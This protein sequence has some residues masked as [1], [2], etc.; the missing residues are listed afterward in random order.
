MKDLESGKVWHKVVTCQEGVRSKGGKKGGG[1]EETCQPMLQGAGGVIIGAGF[2][3]I[4]RCTA[5]EEGFG[6]NAKTK[7]CYETKP[8]SKSRMGK[9]RGFNFPTEIEA[10]MFKQWPLMLEMLDLPMPPGLEVE[11]V[12]TTS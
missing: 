12:E 2:D 9:Q 4:W 5:N 7:F 10:D 11:K 1:L 8:D 6:K 3:F